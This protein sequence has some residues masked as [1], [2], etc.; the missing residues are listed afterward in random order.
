MRFAVFSLSLA[1]AGCGSTK[2]VQQTRSVTRTV[3]TT[4]TVTAKTAASQSEPVVYVETC[5]GVPPGLA[6]KPREISYYGGQQYIRRIR[7][8]TYGGPTALGRAEWGQNDCNP[9]CADGHYTYTPVTV[10]LETRE[11]CHGATAYR[12]WTI[13]GIDLGPDVYQPQPINR[14]SCR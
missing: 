10:K 12:D 1:L 14:E 7:W 2:V 5:C 11:F 6:Y 4:L 9:S 8:V 3:T 13:T